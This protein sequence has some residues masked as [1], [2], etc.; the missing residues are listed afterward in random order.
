MA[1]QNLVTVVSLV[2]AESAT[3]VMLRCA[4][5]AGEFSTTWATRCSARARP[6]SS[7]LIRTSGL[8]SS[9]GAAVCG[10]EVILRSYWLSWLEG[11]AIRRMEQG[12]TGMGASDGCDMP[13][14][15]GCSDRID[16]TVSVPIRTVS[17]VRRRAPRA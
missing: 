8:A 5:A 4:T 14:R 17:G 16:P 2:P 12:I 6:G 3:S 9:I 1:L 11:S 15:G 10:T 7:D 13:L